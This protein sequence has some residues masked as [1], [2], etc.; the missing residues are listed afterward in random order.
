MQEEFPIAVE[1][2]DALEPAIPGICAVL[3]KH[4]ITE[5]MGIDVTEFIEALSKDEQDSR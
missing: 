1:V 2:L 3:H 4:G 5:F